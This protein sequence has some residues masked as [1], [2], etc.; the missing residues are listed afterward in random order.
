M[1]QDLDHVKSVMFV[2]E[3]RPCYDLDRI[4]V[5]TEVTGYLTNLTPLRIGSG[6]GSA[7]F[8]DTTDNPIL[9][10]GDMPYIP[11]SSLKGALRSWL[12]ANVEGLYGRLGQKY[13]KVYPITARDNEVKSCVKSSDTQGNQVEEYCIPCIIFGHKDLSA[14]MNIMDATVEG[15]F[16]VE[17]YTGVSINR[18]FG[19]Q[20]PGHLFTFDYVSPGAKFR[21]RS[22]IYNVNVE[23]ETE[24]WR[25]QVRRGVVF[26]LRSLEEGLFI[27]ARKTTGAGLVKLQDIRVRTMVPGQPWREVK[28]AEVKL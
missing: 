11:G 19:G 15:S 24:E 10:R 5:V 7:S 4:K 2:N 25:E 17:S 26:L 23:N 9:T 13:T 12:E 16:K 27:G 22:I 20:S 1:V 8:R 3:E 14:R 18:V 6:K 28:W 21:F